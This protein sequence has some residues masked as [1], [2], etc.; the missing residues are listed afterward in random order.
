MEGNIIKIFLL[1]S[2]DFDWPIQQDDWDRLVDF[3]ASVLSIK[4][5]S[6]HKCKHLLKKVRVTSGIC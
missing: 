1:P 2:F 4:K 3:F 6:S 5:S